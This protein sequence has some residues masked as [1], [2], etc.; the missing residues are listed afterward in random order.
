MRERERER[1]KRAGAA[2][3]HIGANASNA[4]CSLRSTERSEEERAIFRSL[5]RS[6]QCNAPCCISREL[7]ETMGIISKV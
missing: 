1:E 2:A 6:T 3:K 4:L 7:K 5:A